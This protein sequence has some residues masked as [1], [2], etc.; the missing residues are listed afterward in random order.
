MLASAA[1]LPAP[2]QTLTVTNRQRPVHQDTYRNDTIIGG[3][4]LT[5]SFN[6]PDAT[7]AGSFNHS[8]SHADPGTYPL[9]TAS[10]SAL[11]NS[12]ITATPTTLDVTGSLQA[13]TNLATGTSNGGFH[14][15]SASAGMRSQVYVQFTI[16]APFQ[17][18]LQATT[19]RSNQTP[20][21][22]SS[23]VALGQNGTRSSPGPSNPLYAFGESV[24]SA[25]TNALGHTAATEAGTVSGVPPAGTYEF[26]ALVYEATSS[27]RPRRTPG[28]GRPA[29]RSAS[30]RCRSRPPAGWRRPPGWPPPAG[31]AAAGPAGEAA[32]PAGPVSTA[33]SPRR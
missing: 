28:T 32:D 4:G 9:A 19:I 33:P 14:S 12:T 20:P 7:A 31:S 3:G 23:Y 26:T 24:G 8:N 27:N 6:P 18:T 25:G 29:S 11:H 22:R 1:G 2:A 5:Q 16:D 30:P 15:G 21:S 17:F 10:S 13:T